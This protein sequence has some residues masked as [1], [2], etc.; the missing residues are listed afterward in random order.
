MT[1]ESLDSSV[2]A[3][4]VVRFDGLCAARDALRPPEDGGSGRAQRRIGLQSVIVQA[5]G[6]CLSSVS[7]KDQGQ[8]NASASIYSAEY[9]VCMKLILGYFCWNASIEYWRLDNF[10]SVPTLK[11]MANNEAMRC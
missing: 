10:K 3:H 1:T 7:C 5:T 11:S 9:S 8:G 2:D 6:V 4:R